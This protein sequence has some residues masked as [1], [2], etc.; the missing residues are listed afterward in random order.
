[1][2]KQIFGSSLSELFGWR[3]NHADRAIHFL[4]GVCFTP[5]ITQHFS[6]RYHLARHTALKLAIGIIMVS[7]LCY[8]WFEWLVAVTLSPED[9]EAYNGQQGDM[10]DAHKDML[11]ATMGSLLWWFY[12]RND[13]KKRYKLSISLFN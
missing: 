7:S 10:W 5:A 1:M 8:E 9:A 12:Y 4:Y 3:R 11:C 13:N 6:Q 2:G